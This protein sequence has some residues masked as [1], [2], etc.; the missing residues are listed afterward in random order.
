M[1]KV[2][3]SKRIFFNPKKFQPTPIA[4]KAVSEKL[5]PGSSSEKENIG[6]RRKAAGGLIHTTTTSHCKKSLFKKIGTR[7]LIRVKSASNS[8]KKNL[9][10]RHNSSVCVQKINSP[11]VAK[12]ESSK[13]SKFRKIGNKKLVRVKSVG[14]LT[15]PPLTSSGGRYKLKT[16][17][18][19]IAK[20]PR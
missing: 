6:S 5:S 12:S 4:P 18:K 19:I 15:T 14:L 13:S 11:I 9:S 1:K 3:E 17:R 2:I 7:K 10:N 16:N 8:S 20:T